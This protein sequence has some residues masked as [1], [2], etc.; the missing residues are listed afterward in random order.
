MALSIYFY[1]TS[2]SGKRNSKRLL[3]ANNYAQVVMKTIKAMHD[4]VRDL[5][6]TGNGIVKKYVLLRHLVMPEHEEEGET[7]LACLLRT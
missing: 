2:G 7:L 1:H 6:S 4:Q 3:K 5:C